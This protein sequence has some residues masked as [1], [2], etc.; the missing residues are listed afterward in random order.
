M[1]LLTIKELS[2]Q[3]QIKPSTLYAWVAQQKI[4]YRK[5]HGLV[6]FDATEIDRWI[7]SFVHPLPSPAP[8]IGH[9]TTSRQVE[10][11][12]AQAKREVYTS[13]GETRP[14]ASPTRKEAAN[15]AR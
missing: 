2:K 12:I 3:L 1:L 9:T 10:Q 15:G 11:V 13:R 6:R 14:I 4:P 8:R 5:I 7:A